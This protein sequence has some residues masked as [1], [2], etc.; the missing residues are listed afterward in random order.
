VAEATL[1][2]VEFDHRGR[3]L[4]VCGVSVSFGGVIAVNDVSIEVAPGEGRRTDR[5]NGAGKTTLLDLITGF[6][7][8]STGTILLD[9]ADVSPWVPERTCARR[10]LPV[11]AVGGALRTAHRRV[12]T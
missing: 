8:Q 3:T 6:T 5:P 9:G 12:T 11:V 10:Y 4:E 1:T 7:R 2:K